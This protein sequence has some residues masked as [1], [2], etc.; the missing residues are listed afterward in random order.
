MKFKR[1]KNVIMNIYISTNLYTPDELEDIFLLMNKINDENIGIELFPEWHN[2]QFIDVIDRNLDKLKNYNISLHGPY[3]HTEH[4]KEKGTVEYENSKEYFISTFKLSKQ[5]NSNYIVYHHNNCKV[6][7]EN[8]I[9]MI[10][11]ASD[12]LVELNDLSEV[13][14]ANI[15]VENAGVLSRNS[16]LFDEE[17]FIEMAKSIDNKILIDIGHAFA[18]NW[19]LNRV[20]YELK[21]KIVSYHLHNNDGI[22]DAHNRIRD[23]KINI[24]DFFEVYRK[25]TPQAHLVLEYSKECRKDINGI[26]EDLNE[27][28]HL[29][30]QNFKISG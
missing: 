13:Y 3:Y 19:N 1:G 17:E 22:Q 12:N 29:C 26:I 30:S 18:N 9:E 10:N 2:K 8:K 25:C 21:D 16:M 15:V 11:N 24:D 4:S 6:K 7:L 27:I 14:G 5:L 28:R 20:I 23:G